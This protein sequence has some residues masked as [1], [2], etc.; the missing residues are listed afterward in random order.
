MISADNIM[1]KRFGSHFSLLKKSINNMEEE[2][3]KFGGL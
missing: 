2:C 3:H 1:M